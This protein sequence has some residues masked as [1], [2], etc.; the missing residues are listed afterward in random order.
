MDFSPDTLSYGISRAVFRGALG[1][2]I[3]PGSFPYVCCE[4][5]SYE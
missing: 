5:Q 1:C 4:S 3:Y 2:L